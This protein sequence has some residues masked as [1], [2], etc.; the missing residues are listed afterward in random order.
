MRKICLAVLLL[1]ALAWAE[2]KSADDW[3]KEGANQYNLGRRGFDKFAKRQ[4]EAKV[5]I[6]HEAPG[7]QDCFF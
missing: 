5:T 6:I 1:P 7:M 4:G 2:P 3:Y